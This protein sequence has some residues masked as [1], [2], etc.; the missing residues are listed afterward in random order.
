MHIRRLPLAV[1]GLL[2][3]LALA[4]PAPGAPPP[5]CTPSPAWPAS[6][7]DLAGAVVSLINAHRTG[8]GL[9]PLQISPALS[10]AA[11]WKARDMAGRGYFAHDDP[12]PPVARSPGERIAACGYTDAAWGE[13]IAVGYTA[14]SD[15]VAA[16][17]A[18]PGHR[19][20]IEDPAFRVT[21]VAVAGD[22]VYW[23]QEFGAR[24]DPPPEPRRLA[25]TCADRGPSHVSC[26]VSARSGT[27][28]TAALR[29]A[30]HTFARASGLARDGIAR[31]ALLSDRPLASGRY[32]VTVR[33]VF[34]S[35]TRERHVTLTVR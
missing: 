6:R 1:A 8:M 12:G 3:A 7:P 33:A 5:D 24:A 2:G 29:R 4:G 14:P 30:G 23:A 25:A 16:W 22:P 20:N 15:V 31:L 32:R 11:E 10:A 34:A 9:Q 19:E 18:S 17:I 21:G 13:N 26:R 28:I 35:R 27:A